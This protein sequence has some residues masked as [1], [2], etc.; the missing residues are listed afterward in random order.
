MNTIEKKRATVDKLLAEEAAVAK[1]A[2]RI[3]GLITQWREAEN[4]LINQTGL[5]DEAS[6]QKLAD[7]RIR[8]EIAGHKIPLLQESSVALHNTVHAVAKELGLEL[9]AAA[10]ARLEAVRESTAARLKELYPKRQAV[11]LV[12]LANETDVVEDAHR[13]FL[14]ISYA[15]SLV[16]R[17]TEDSNGLLKLILDKAATA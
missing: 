9:Q 3:E 5:E 12:T 4:K 2:A 16:D 11:E 8:I 14:N 15:T 7:L 1:E 13:E 17:H 6:R 10:Q